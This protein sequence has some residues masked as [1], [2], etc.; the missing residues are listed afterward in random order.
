MKFVQINATCGVGSTGKICVDISKLLTEKNIENYILYSGTKSDYPLGIL[1]GDTKQIKFQAL[2]SH[3][4][5]RYGFNSKQITQEILHKL[6]E[7]KPDIVHLH[8][9]HGHNCNIEILFGY[10]REQHIKTYW[11]FHDCW[12]FTAYC[13]HFTMNK[14]DK[15]KD[16]CYECARYKEYSFFFDKSE[17]LYEKKKKMISGLD[18]TVTTPSRWISNLVKQSFFKD[19]PVKVI[20]NGIDLDTFKPTLSNFREKYSVGDKKIIL[21]V[22]FGWGKHKGLDVFVELAK[23]LDKEKYQIVLV[24]TDDSVDRQLPDS[25]ISIHRTQNQA[26]LAEI[27]T[28]AD[29]FANPTREEVLGLVNLETLACGTPGVTFDTGGSPECYDVSCGAVVPCDD[30]DTMEKEIIRICET[31]PYSVAA[32]LKRAKW[33]DKNEKYKEYMELYHR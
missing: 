27:Y 22:A 30:I 18:L 13:P 16:G 7:I 31:K 4:N 25:I 28:A 3:I 21:G 20:H 9:L 6:D 11:T 15:W 24:G 5:G 32:C 33:F 14:C 17:Q 12:A 23:R 29:V 8:N 26:E 1:C 10:L 2:L 19:Y